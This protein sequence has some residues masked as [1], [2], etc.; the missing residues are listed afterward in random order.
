MKLYAPK[1]MTW[2]IALILG[3]VGIV[4]SF[5]NIPVLSGLAFW[6]VIVAFVLLVLGTM[7]ETF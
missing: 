4:A 6:L 7:V 3:L 5:V 1:A 2:R